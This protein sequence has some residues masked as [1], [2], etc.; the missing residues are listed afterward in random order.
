[1]DKD[2]WVNFLFLLNVCYTS[3]GLHKFFIMLFLFICM[4]PFVVFHAPPIAHKDHQVHFS[5]SVCHLSIRLSIHPPT[6]WEVCTSA[7]G[8]IC[9]RGWTWHSSLLTFMRFLLINIHK[10]IFICIF[11]TYRLDGTK[12]RSCEWLVSTWDSQF[13][14]SV[15]SVKM[16]GLLL[17]IP[18]LYVFFLAHRW[19]SFSGHTCS[20]PQILN[21]LRVT[22][23]YIANH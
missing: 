21:F 22:S 17:T 23:I 11:Y 18:V 10:Y 12:M 4:C 14:R 9:P 1:M 3:V 5:R 15:T 19:H 20:T 7:R 2:I 6:Q 8:W 16:L 13:H